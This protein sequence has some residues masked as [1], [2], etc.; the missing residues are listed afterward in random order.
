LYSSPD[1]I[2]AVKSRRVRWV[3]HAAYFGKMRNSY[4]IVGEKHKRMKQL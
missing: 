1:I 3:K 2:K 4:N